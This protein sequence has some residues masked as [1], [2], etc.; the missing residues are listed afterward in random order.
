ML[1]ADQHAYGDG[2]AQL[3]T[4]VPPALVCIFTTTRF[5][6]THHRPSQG[7]PR[8]PA[9]A[10]GASQRAA[11]LSRV[12]LAVYAAGGRGIHLPL[13]QDH[14]LVSVVAAALSTGVVMDEG[15]RGAGAAAAAG[16]AVRKGAAEVAGALLDQAVQLQAGG[17]GD[18]AA[19]GGGGGAQGRALFSRLLALHALAL[20]EPALVA[21]QK[22]PQRF[23]RTL[24]PYATMPDA[25]ALAAQSDGEG[26]LRIL[27]GGTRPRPRPPLLC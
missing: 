11:E 21:P 16:K 6:T 14:P 18:D 9:G 26:P 5:L 25:E 7:L 19:D 20:A 10:A 4:Y 23:V 1:A 15:A 13:T 27:F 12:A 24:A 17:D 22:D 8:A 3:L 2:T